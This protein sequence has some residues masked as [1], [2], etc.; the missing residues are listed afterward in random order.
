MKTETAKKY[1]VIVGASPSDVVITCGDIAGIYRKTAREED[2][3]LAKLYARGQIQDTFDMVL[4][5]INHLNEI[6]FYGRRV[7]CFEYIALIEFTNATTGISNILL[8]SFTFEARTK[9]GGLSMK[10]K[11]ITDAITKKQENELFETGEELPALPFA[12]R[13]TFKPNSFKDKNDQTVNFHIAKYT[14]ID[15]PEWFADAIQ[16]VTAQKPM[17]TRYPGEDLALSSSQQRHLPAAVA[18]GAL[19]EPQEVHPVESTLPSAF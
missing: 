19:D 15:E 4:I 7:E 14:P 5:G 9:T 2:E 6:D 11:A 8:S 1:N 13:V 10:V 12:A 3:S 18:T 16:K 17:L